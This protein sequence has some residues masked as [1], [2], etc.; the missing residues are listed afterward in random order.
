LPGG[1]GGDQRLGA[2]A[3]R[4]ADHIGAT[5]DSAATR[6]AIAGRVVSICGI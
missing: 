3:A 5:R 2:I 1:D 4:H 6:P